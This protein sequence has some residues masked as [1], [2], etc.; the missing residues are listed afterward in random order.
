MFQYHTGPIKRLSISE[1]LDLEIKFQYHTGPIKRRCTVFACG[2]G[3]LFQYHTGPIKSSYAVYCIRV[4]TRSFNTTLVQLK[5]CWGSPSRLSFFA[6]F[7]YHTG[8]IKSMKRS[9]EELRSR[10]EVSIPH[11][12]N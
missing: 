6:V 7:Q 10:I 2:Q 8:P 5:A 9:Y 12:S 11:W 3:A 1:E 4:V